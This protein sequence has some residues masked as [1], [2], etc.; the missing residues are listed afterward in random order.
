MNLV[1]IPFHDW[2]KSEREGFRTRDV[3]LLEEFGKHP[4]VE[5]ILVV[6][7]PLFPLEMLQKQVFRRDKTVRQ[8]AEKIYTVDSVLF[9]I[10]QPLDI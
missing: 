6:N 1:C 10:W 5:K 2:N 8:V 4:L 3:H 9:H 7:R